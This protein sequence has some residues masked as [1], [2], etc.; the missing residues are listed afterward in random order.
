MQLIKYATH[1][2]ILIELWYHNM[3]SS[4][5]KQSSLHLIVAHTLLKGFNKSIKILK[6][7]FYPLF[8]L[9]CVSVFTQNS[10]PYL[11][12]TVNCTKTP[13]LHPEPLISRFLL[14]FTSSF[15]RIRLFVQVAVIW[16]RLSIESRRRWK[17]TRHDNDGWLAVSSLP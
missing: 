9:F 4:S 15:S 11:Q 12:V 2:L 7:S 10:Q 17:Y 5:T 8:T 16:G 14:L 13:F 1:N 3:I 6:T